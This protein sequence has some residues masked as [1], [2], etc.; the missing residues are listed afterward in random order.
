MPCS[1]PVKVYSIY[2]YIYICASLKLNTGAVLK[3]K[4]E[5]RYCQI[6]RCVLK[7]CKD[8]IINFK[9]KQSPPHNI[10]IALLKY[11]CKGEGEGLVHIS[12]SRR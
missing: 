2:I 8:T 11:C 5:S 9:Y 6:L 1:V 10:N 4:E 7:K 12:L 3:T